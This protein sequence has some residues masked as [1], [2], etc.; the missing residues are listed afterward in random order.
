MLLH[1]TRRECWVSLCWCAGVH[2]WRDPH[3]HTFGSGQGVAADR[4]ERP[5]GGGEEA[6]PSSSPSSRL[7]LADDFQN[8]QLLAPAL[9]FAEAL[10]EPSVP[11]Q[12]APWDFNTCIPETL[13]DTL[14]ERAAMWYFP[15]LLQLS[16][17]SSTT[18]STRMLYTA[19]ASLLSQPMEACRPLHKVST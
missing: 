5:R 19:Q 6:S 14:R 3:G 1:S 15:M 18:N 4:L 11:G 16:G 13:I 9:G 17:P 8:I 2:R 12:Q 7:L 10:P